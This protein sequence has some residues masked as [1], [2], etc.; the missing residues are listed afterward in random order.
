MFI[1]YREADVKNLLK[2]MRSPEGFPITINFTLY[3]GPGAALGAQL[4]RDSF[5]KANMISTNNMDTIENAIV[6]VLENPVVDLRGGAFPPSPR[7]DDW[8][9][10]DNVRQSFHD[11]MFQI[12]SSLDRYFVT[13]M[14]SNQ[15]A[16]E[17]RIYYQVTI[18]HLKD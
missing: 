14:V 8:T 16:S 12:K 10:S 2:K 13:G 3:Y 15:N 17:K 1:S 4:S 6:G 7:V 11:S 5:P 9:N 18:E